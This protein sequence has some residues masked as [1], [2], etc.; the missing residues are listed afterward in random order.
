MTPSRLPAFRQRAMMDLLS[1]IC[2]VLELRHGPIHAEFR[3]NEHGIWP[4]E[5]AA[6]TIGGRCARL[7]TVGS[8]QTLEELVILQALGRAPSLEP[9]RGASGVLMLPVPGSGVV[10][11][12]EGI[13]EARGGGRHHRRGKWMSPADR[14]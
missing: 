5:V 6:R 4:V 13:G 11:R 12:T 14:C 10:R 8:S 7:L 3:F 2:R 9:K 1:R